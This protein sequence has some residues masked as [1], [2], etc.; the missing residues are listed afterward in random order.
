[1]IGWNSGAKQIKGYTA[2]EIIGRHFSIFYP[3]EDV[4]AGIPDGELV[5]AKA[6]G[7]FEAEG[8][9]VRKDGSSFWADVVITPLYDDQQRH[10]GYAKVTRDV[11]VAHEQSLALGRAAER[12]PNAN[13]ALRRQG[14]QLTEARD[15]AQKATRDAQAATMAKSAFLATMSHEIRTPMNAVI[16]MTGLLLD[17]D[18][19]AD[20]RDYVETVR[21]SSDSLLAVINDIL[22]Y[23]KIES[24]RLDLESLPFDVRDLVESAVELVGS[25]ASAKSLDIL[26]DISAGCPPILVGD[27]TRL[28]QVLVNLLSNAVKFTSVGE[29]MATLETMN[30]A[31]GSRML[32]VAVADTGIGIPADRMDRL[33]RSFS[34]VETSTTRTY[35]GT[36]LGLVISAHLIEAMG[37]KIR[38]DSEPGHGSTFSFAIPTTSVDRPR[39][40]NSL[41]RGDMAGL[42][43]L[44]VDDN[45]NNR[46]I[47]QSQLEGWGATSDSSEGGA[48]ALELACGD[49][50]YDIAVLDMDMPG[51]DGVELAARLQELDGYERLP[52]VLLSSQTL[53]HDR[54]RER[55]FT[56]QLVKPV[57]SLQLHRTILGA[58]RRQLAIAP[59]PSDSNV[60]SPAVA[61]RVLIAEDNPINQKVAALML[62]QLNCR[63]ALAGNGIEAVAAAHRAP[64]DIIFMDVVMP[65]MDGLEA[66]RRIRSELPANHQPTIIAV[67][68][69]AMPEDR[70]ACL[71]AGMDNY[72]PKP[73]KKEQLAAV[74]AESIPI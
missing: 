25:Q 13:V 1:V 28:H 62:K 50:H 18:L 14:A 41:A 10:R 55:F 46:R 63:A 60:R 37:G 3:P 20:Q 21:S 31:D 24:G 68:A 49:R 15:L 4:A 48:A 34:Q 9:R 32:H 36:G 33:F 38:V 45:A 53:R 74:L 72:L 11:S 2:Q 40:K 51:M 44:V 22:D 8:W 23:S 29:V 59:P 30:A 16:G 39:P 61:L 19:D 35:G 58:L 64:Y 65:E 42:H 12:M 54:R 47:L 7:R 5:A 17:T 56:A 26:I 6:D 66:T 73:L 71:R 67:T 52:L 70:A 57:K 43:V 69:N 27:V